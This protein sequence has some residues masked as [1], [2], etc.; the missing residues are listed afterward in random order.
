MHIRSRL[1][2]FVL[3][4]V[5]L[6]AAMTS[7]GAEPPWSLAELYSKPWPFGNGFRHVALSDDG[8]WLA[9]AWDARAES[10]YDA[11]HIQ[12]QNKRICPGWMAGPCDLIID[13]VQPNGMHLHPD[14]PG[15]GTRF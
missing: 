8:A 13:R 5:L 9:C 14:F 7:A 4:S 6:L 3:P 1:L 11:S 10:I 12:A 15:S 2:L